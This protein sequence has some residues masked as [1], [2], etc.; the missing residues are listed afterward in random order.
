MVNKERLGGSYRLSAYYLAKSFSELPYS[1]V[2]PVVTFL[3]FYSMAGLNGLTHVGSFFGSLAVVLTVA[4]TA[5]SLGE[6]LDRGKRE[7]LWF[8]SE[9]M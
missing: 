1:L 5:Q 6:P 4:I 8:D 2:M 9:T 3:M 7:N